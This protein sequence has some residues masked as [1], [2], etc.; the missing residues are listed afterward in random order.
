[1][2]ILRRW[3]CSWPLPTEGGSGWRRHWFLRRGRRGWHQGTGDGAQG[4]GRS[5]RSSCEGKSEACRKDQHGILPNSS[6]L[7][8]LFI[9]FAAS[10]HQAL[11]WWDRHGRY[12]GWCACHW[13]GRSSLGILSVFFFEFNHLFW[14]HFFFQPSWL[15]SATESR[16]CRFIISVINISEVTCHSRLFALLKMIRS[17]LTTS[18][19]ASV[20]WRTMC[21]PWTVCVSTPFTNQ[22]WSELYF[23][24]AAMNKVWGHFLKQHLERTKWS[25]FNVAAVL[26]FNGWSQMWLWVEIFSWRERFSNCLCPP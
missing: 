20:L 21:N 8:L 12:G 26:F 5:C 22:V 19:S 1:M 9:L 23:A 4:P 25:A 7:R 14:C 16:S 10:R 2:A 3:T 13:N 17:P 15:L 11:G 6:F 24:V 18:T